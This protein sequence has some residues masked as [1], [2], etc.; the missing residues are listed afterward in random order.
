M[1][2]AVIN[3]VTKIIYLVLISLNTW[4]TDTLFTLNCQRP[5]FIAQA[6]KYMGYMYILILIEITVLT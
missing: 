4:S 1:K 5:K 2:F 3:T 6:F